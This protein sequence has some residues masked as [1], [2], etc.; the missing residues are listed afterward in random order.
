MSA[1]THDPLAPG[2]YVNPAPFN[3]VVAEELT[4]AEERFYRA[5]ALTLI[6][7]KFKRHKVALISAIFLG[8]LYL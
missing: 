6:W 8:L 4:A 1:I 7:W 5:S 2:H 3:P